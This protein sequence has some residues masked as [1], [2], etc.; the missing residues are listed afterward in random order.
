MRNRG[1]KKM[2]AI[3]NKYDFK[4]QQEQCKASDRFDMRVAIAKQ[5]SHNVI[6]LSGKLC[7][8]VIKEMMKDVYRKKR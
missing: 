5:V 4:R 3:S 8:D 2:Q 7:D 6:S 1:G